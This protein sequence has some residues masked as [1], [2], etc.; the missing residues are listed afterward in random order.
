MAGG[1]HS[2]IKSLREYLK[3]LCNSGKTRPEII[4]IVFAD[5]YFSDINAVL[6]NFINI[7]CDHLGGSTHAEILFAHPIYKNSKI[8]IKSWL[9][10]TSIS[11]INNAPQAIAPT[12]NTDCTDINLNGTSTTW[13]G[14]V[15]YGRDA[16]DTN[17]FSVSGAGDVNGD[18]YDDILIGAPNAYG[19]SNEISGSGEFYLVLGDL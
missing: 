5:G 11:E 6:E 8:H 10:D 1:W 7:I 4:D 9:L 19:V 13:Q 15:M 17:G 18:G 3:P 2:T 14:M 12:I 16:S